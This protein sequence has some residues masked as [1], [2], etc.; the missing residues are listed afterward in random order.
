LGLEVPVD[1]LDLQGLYRLR[2]RLYLWDPEI[3]QYLEALLDLEVLVL[4]HLDM[5]YV[6]S[7]FT[8]D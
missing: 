8:I 4:L 2:F 1:P 5:P 6:E 3:L 7:L